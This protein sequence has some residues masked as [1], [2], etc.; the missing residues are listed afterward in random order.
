MVALSVLK[1]HN[2]G[3][4]TSIPCPIFINGQWMERPENK[5]KI[6]LWEN[7]ERDSII[8]D[9]YNTMNSPIPISN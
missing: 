5:R 7:F 9:F 8:S 3:E 6:I 4:S 2:W 1:N